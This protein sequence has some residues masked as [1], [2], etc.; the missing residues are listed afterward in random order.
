MNG[1]LGAYEG[2]LAYSFTA[3]TIS[4][5]HTEAFVVDGNTTEPDFVD[6]AQ[7]AQ[8]DAIA[9]IL[10]AAASQLRRVIILLANPIH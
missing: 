4:G 3:I 1:A 2:E 7:D 6:D 9:G 5:F 8:N 10:A